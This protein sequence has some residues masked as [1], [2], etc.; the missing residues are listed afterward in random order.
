MKRHFVAIAV[1]ASALSLTMCSPKAELCDDST[2]TL[3][4]WSFSRDSVSW[5]N[6]VIPHSTN[7]IDGHSE[8]YYRGKTYYKTSIDVCDAAKPVYILFEGAAQKS[9]VYLNGEL[10]SNHGGGYTAFTVDATSKV[11][12]GENDILVVCDN[13]E[14]IELIPVSSDFN[15]NN[16]LHNEVRL[17]QKDFVHIDPI[18]YGPYRFNAYSE[19]VEGGDVDVKVIGDKTSVWSDE[20]L[21]VSTSVKNLLGNAAVDVLCRVLDADGNLA[22]SSTKMIDVSQGVSSDVTMEIEVSDAHMWHGKHD[23]YLYTIEIQALVDGQCVDL[24]SSKFGFRHV[25]LDPERGFMLNGL[26]YPLRGVSVHQDKDGKASAMAKEDY[27]QDYQMISEIGASMVRLAHYPH[28]DYVFR[29]CDSLGL[30]VQTEIPW[31]NVCGVRAT[32]KYFD[33]IHSQATEMAHNLMNHPSICFWGLWNELDTWG[34]NDHFQGQLDCEAVVRETA[35]AYDVVR[36][37]DP[38]R[39]IGITD[40]SVLRNSGYTNLKADFISENRYNG[41]Y[42]TPNQFE[43]FTSDM[44]DIRAKSSCKIINVSE[45]GVGINPYCH[46]SDMTCFKGD[47]DK[48][49]HY[50]EYGN[51]SHESHWQQICAMPWLNFTT[52]WVMYDFAVANREEGYLDSSDGINFVENEWRKYTNDKGLVTRDRKTKKDV[53]YLYKAAWNH[54]VTTVHIANTRLA[55][56]PS[57]KNV[58]VKV[59]SNAKKLSLYQNGE[60][61][62][63]LDQSGEISGVI[64]QFSPLKMQSDKDV[65]R[66]VSDNDVEDSWTLEVL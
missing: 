9:L 34:N 45:Y 53:F 49:H 14:D 5:E 58:T 12:A 16:G 30:V 66:V 65:F 25:S 7:A 20:K 57:D 19:P 64:W 37:I 48:T 52:L 17:I 22:A 50:E 36:A 55:K 42:Y 10:L 47:P 11:K 31:V 41:W 32:Q 2:K 4:N 44:V 54:D 13:T 1:S 38:S 18:K 56:W 33:N 8:N 46:T 26:L 29:L 60:L 27:D 6:V 3:S 23:P 40:C 39:P 62:Q 28:N 61:K 24:T 15:K 21:F 63:T 35:T 43:Y 59:Y 51:L